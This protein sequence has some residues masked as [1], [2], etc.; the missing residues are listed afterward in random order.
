MRGFLTSKDCIRAFEK[1]EDLGFALRDREARPSLDLA[2]EDA[3]SEEFWPQDT[4][5]ARHTVLRAIKERRGQRKFRDSLLCAYNSRCAITSCAI[6][7]VLESAHI[8]PYRGP[9]TNTVN[10]GILLRA[11][12]HTLFDC[13]LISIDV[14]TMK[15]RISPHLHGS[16]YECYQDRLLTLPAKKR[17]WPNR[18]ALKMREEKLPFRDN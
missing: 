18:E 6:V 7:D 13:G 8:Y 11:D 3:T 9:D 14:D 17:C 5:D 16:E 1:L 10:N 15:V 4:E 12:L 2:P